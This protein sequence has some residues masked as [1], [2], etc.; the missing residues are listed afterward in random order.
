MQPHCNQPSRNRCWTILKCYPS[1]FSP[2]HRED[3]VV[4]SGAFRLDSY[5]DTHTGTRWFCFDNPTTGHAGGYRIRPVASLGKSL[6]GRWYALYPRIC[7]HPDC[8]RLGRLAGPSGRISAG[9]TCI[10]RNRGACGAWVGGGY[11]GQGE[12]QKDRTRSPFHPKP[13]ERHAILTHPTAKRI[14]LIAGIQ[15]SAGKVPEQIEHA[16]QDTGF[17]RTLTKKVL[18]SVGMKFAGLTPPNQSRCDGAVGPRPRAVNGPGLPDPVRRASPPDH[19]SI[20]EGSKVSPVAM[21]AR[22]SSGSPARGAFRAKSCPLPAAQGPRHPTFT[23]TISMD[24]TAV[25]RNGCAP[26][27]ASP[28]SISTPIWD[29]DGSPRHA[30]AAFSRPIGCAAPS[31][32]GG[33]NN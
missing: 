5:D 29:G 3:R 15:M 10:S 26:S 25:S 8:D 12:G 9:L 18:T 33:T 4:L 21:A 2:A 17:F 22:P 13:T 32:W 14:N 27:M 11:P 19:P 1:L 7:G 23:S 6:G 30:A 31:G 16:S 24:I 28:P 20:R